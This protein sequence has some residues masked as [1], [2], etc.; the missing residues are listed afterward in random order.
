MGHTC[1]PPVLMRFPKERAS[2]APLRPVIS[3]CSQ[4]SIEGPA[5]SSQIR[6]N[7]GPGR[8]KENPFP[9][10]SAGLS[11]PAGLQHSWHAAGHIAS[12][13]L[14]P[15]GHMALCVPLTAPLLKALSKMLRAAGCS[16][17]SRQNHPPHFSP[18]L[19]FYGVF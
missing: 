13:G 9:H 2:L 11:P 16:C 15:P 18:F 17:P 12:P 10:S 4:L 5:L 8:A 6:G 3:R 7:L 1:F 14:W 19:A